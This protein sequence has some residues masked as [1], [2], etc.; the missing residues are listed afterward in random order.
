MGVKAVILPRE[1]RQI[2]GWRMRGRQQGQFLSRALDHVIWNTI[3]DAYPGDFNFAVRS[4]SKRQLNEEP[5]RVRAVLSCRVDRRLA[6]EFGKLD[7]EQ[8]LLRWILGVLAIHVNRDRL[9][10]S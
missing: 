6:V 9:F 3:H 1:A 4:I 2:R 7:D 5:V 10:L 8:R